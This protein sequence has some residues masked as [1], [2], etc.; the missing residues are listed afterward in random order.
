MMNLHLNTY[1]IRFTIK[2]IVIHANFVSYQT[3]THPKPGFLM[4]TIETRPVF[5]SQKTFQSQTP[6]RE[7]T[8]T[9]IDQTKLEFTFSRTAELG[10]YIAIS[11]FEE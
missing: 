10:P 3:N 11:K 5:Q 8:L 7:R 2:I 6:T 1:R 4:K 9:I